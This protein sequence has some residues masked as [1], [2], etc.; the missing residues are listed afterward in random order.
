M[1]LFLTGTAHICIT[2]HTLCTDIERL[3]QLHNIVVV[4]LTWPQV[5]LFDDS[6]STPHQTI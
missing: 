3:D 6:Y 1:V 2:I 5:R 4:L